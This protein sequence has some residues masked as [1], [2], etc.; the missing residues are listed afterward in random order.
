MNT[1]RA[2]ELRDHLTAQY[3]ALFNAAEHF[4]FT[5]DA[6]LKR[7]AELLEKLPAK[8]PGW[9]KQYLS[10]IWEQL[11]HDAYQRDLVYG[12]WING[13]FAST[14]STRP[15]YYENLGLSAREWHERATGKGHHWR[16]NTVHDVVPFFVE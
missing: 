14:H 2:L 16:A 5:H 15:D 7:R 6:M 10:G 8:A 3:R 12:G 11:Q 9:I 1:K 4:G 13:T